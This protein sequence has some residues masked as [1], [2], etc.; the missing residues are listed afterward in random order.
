MV[1]GTDHLN[2]ARSCQARVLMRDPSVRKDDGSRPRTGRPV[3]ATAG[4]A[5]RPAVARVS[6]QAAYLALAA[7]AAAA[8]SGLYALPDQSIS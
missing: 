7:R 1:R 2:G 3:R 8:S 6:L 4:G 5:S